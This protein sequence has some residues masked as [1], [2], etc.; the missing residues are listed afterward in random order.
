MCYF[1]CS[2]HERGA[3]RRAATDAEP[4]QQPRRPLHEAHRRPER[5]PPLW[6]ERLQ[7]SNGGTGQRVAPPLEAYTGTRRPQPPGVFPGTAAAAT[8]AAAAADA[9]QQHARSTVPAPVSA[10]GKGVMLRQQAPPPVQSQRV[11]ADRGPHH[12]Q[13]QIGAQASQRVS[14]SMPSGQGG[15]AFPAPSGTPDTSVQQPPDGRLSSAAS[16]QEA[17]MQATASG[18]PASSGQ[19]FVSTARAAV[20]AAAVAKCLPPLA[21]AAGNAGAFGS[22]HDLLRTAK[23][24]GWMT[25]KAL[26]GC[27]AAPT[28]APVEGPPLPHHTFPQPTAT[29]EELL[30][31]AAASGQLPPLTAPPETVHAE[32]WNH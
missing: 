12:S 23:K 7:G 17:S 11:P 26:E 16:A 22:E 28:V 18:Q 9:A 24:Q 5:R 6:R 13:Q 21:K 2:S 15:I 27:H 20:D 10:P 31:S 19:P 8:A 1:L 29:A 30:S 3:S 32:A 4:R 14:L 25:A